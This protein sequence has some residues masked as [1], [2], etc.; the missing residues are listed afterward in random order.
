MSDLLAQNSE[1]S[2]Q[3][4]CQ[5]IKKYLEHIPPANHLSAQRKKEAIAKERN[6]VATLTK[7]L[8]L[9]YKTLSEPV[10]GTPKKITCLQSEE[11]NFFA[12]TESQVPQF[13]NPSVQLSPN[14]SINNLACILNN[15]RR[16]LENYGCPIREIGICACF[17]HQSRKYYSMF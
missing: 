3:N 2:S 16:E 9:L 8:Q 11:I 13:S 12:L 17:F 4:I 15:A 5:K 14:W 7:D 6:R 1:Q 10:H